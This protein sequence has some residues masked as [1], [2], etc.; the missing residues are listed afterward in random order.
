MAILHHI[1][2]RYFVLPVFFTHYL[3]DVLIIPITATTALWLQ[4]RFIVRNN[5]FQFSK[6]TL[7]LLVVYFTIA[8]EWIIPRFSTHFTADAWDIAAY[9]TGACL[10]HLFINKRRAIACTSTR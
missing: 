4:R 5:E 1:I 3:D 7:T 9:T 6:F 2:Q 10:F 8:F